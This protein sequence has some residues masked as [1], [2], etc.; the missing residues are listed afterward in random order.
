MWNESSGDE[1]EDWKS[2]PSPRAPPTRRGAALLQQAQWARAAAPPVHIGTPLNSPTGSGTS[3][4]DPDAAAAAEEGGDEAE[5]GGSAAE[6]AGGGGTPPA[7]DAPPHPLAKPLL[8]LLNY[9]VPDGVM[10]E[11]EQI[12]E[13]CGEQ[14][15][16]LPW[17]DPRF[18]GHTACAQFVSQ[19]MGVPNRGAGAVYTCTPSPWPLHACEADPGIGELMCEAMVPLMDGNGGGVFRA[20]F[21]GCLQS[22]RHMTRDTDWPPPCPP[23]VVPKDI[24]M[25]VL[26]AGGLK[27][28]FLVATALQ[29]A[30]QHP[31][32]SR[33]HR[34]TDISLMHG[35]EDPPPDP[36][37][38]PKKNKKNDAHVPTGPK[39]AS[40]SARKRTLSTD[41]TLAAAVV[42]SVAKDGSSHLL[43]NNIFKSLAADATDTD[44]MVHEE[45]QHIVQLLLGDSADHLLDINSKGHLSKAAEVPDDTKGTSVGGAGGPAAWFHWFT[46]NLIL[47]YLEQAPAQ[48]AEQLQHA[49]LSASKKD[50]PRLPMDAIRYWLFCWTPGHKLP[51]ASP[52]L[53]PGL[54]RWAPGE[55]WAAQRFLDLVTAHVGECVDQGRRRF[56]QALHSGLETRS[57]KVPPALD[58]RTERA[59]LFLRIVIMVLERAFVRNP[60]YAALVNRDARLRDVERALEGALAAY[61]GI[62]PSWAGSSVTTLPPWPAPPGLGVRA[63]P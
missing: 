43:V 22:T 1:E 35:E 49:G 41:A 28:N 17:V 25:H 5:G 2:V 15:M 34:R 33:L 52:D 32:V 24:L 14:R 9:Q 44:K 13:G 59:R 4:I 27:P 39:F 61:L 57:I 46:R 56:L 11:S 12:L 19:T 20:D 31:K 40:E 6:D 29:V 55:R 50:V 30:K 7:P 8:S 36:K 48:A 37:P 16:I 23:G 54:V 38:K 21:W 53:L 45:R 51:Q 42:Q 3:G 63:W 26:K 62:A 18:W 10:L 60:P 47:R 58:P